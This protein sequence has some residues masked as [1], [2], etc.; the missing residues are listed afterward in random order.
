MLM[1]ERSSKLFLCVYYQF[2]NQNQL[3]TN[4]T[5]SACLPIKQFCITEITF[6]ISGNNQMPRIDRIDLEINDR[7]ISRI[8]GCLRLIL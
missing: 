3:I 4:K 7:A 8:G 1:N 6:A 2:E 5:S